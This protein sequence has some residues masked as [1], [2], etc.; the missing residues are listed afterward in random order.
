V[1]PKQGR[2]WWPFVV[3]PLI[4]I[5]TF[6]IGYQLAIFQEQN[7][8]KL[9][10]HFNFGSNQDS[11]SCHS[12]TANPQPIPCSDLKPGGLYKPVIYLYPTHPE[13]VNVKV[14]YPAGFQATIPSYN[15]ATGWQ[16]TAQP[17]GTL[18]NLADN[19]TYPYLFWEGKPAPLS[20]NMNQGFV[21]ADSDTRSFLQRQLTSMGLNQNETNGFIAFWLPRMESK[22]YNLIHFAGSE[23]TDYA[24][25]TITPQPDSL[26]RV[27]MAFAPIQQ[28]VKVTP[29]SFPTFHRNGFTAVEWGGTELH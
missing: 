12:L 14:T 4:A 11:R 27:F 13:N 21:V 23:Y 10:P 24:K 22:P 15:A 18:T 29:Q 17:S 9:L 16:V 28:P 6:F 5:V 19:K 20:F 25:L 26:L 7:N 1:S 3:V 2:P 8:D